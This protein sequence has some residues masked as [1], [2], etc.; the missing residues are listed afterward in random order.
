MTGWI[1]LGVIAVVSA[2]IIFVDKEK[3]FNSKKGNQEK[4]FT[5]GVKS[6]FIKEDVNTAPAAAGVATPVATPAVMRINEETVSAQVAEEA[7]NRRAFEGTLLSLS[8]QLAQNNTKQ[9]DLILKAEDIERKMMLLAQN[10]DVEGLKL[11]SLAINKLFTEIVSNKSQTEL[12]KLLIMKAKT[13]M[14]TCEDLSKQCEQNISIRASILPQVDNIHTISSINNIGVVSNAGNV[15]NAGGISNAGNASTA[16]NISNAESKSNAGNAVN[17]GHAYRDTL[18][19]H[20]AMTLNAMGESTN[21]ERHQQAVN[22]QNKEDDINV[23]RRQQAVTAQSME[24][25]VRQQQAANAQRQQ[26][27]NTQSVEDVARQQPVV[28]AQR[29]QMASTQSTEDTIM[30]QQA[31]NAPKQQT[32]HVP[33]IEGELNIAQQQ[34]AVNAQNYDLFEYAQYLMTKYNTD[35]KTESIR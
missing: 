7:H 5:G 13:L 18:M 17:P 31:V 16:V 26:M 20:I 9:D 19:A 32:A 33:T 8:N 24:D 15:S 35:S 3:L 1:V 4:S 14:T 22:A 2:F 11:V 29:Q 34:Q 6:L 25:T 10:N 23:A 30:Q 21:P 27:V 12:D 28:N